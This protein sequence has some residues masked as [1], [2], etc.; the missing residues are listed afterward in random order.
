MV[1]LALVCA[2][3]A[4]AALAW[5]LYNPGIDYEF[6]FDDHRAIE[7]NADSR[8]GAP[9]GDLLEHDFWGDNLTCVRLRLCGW[10]AVACGCVYSC[11]CHCICVFLCAYACCVYVCASAVSTYVPAVSMCVSVCSVC[12]CVYGTCVCGCVFR[13]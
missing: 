6:T 8:W 9:W 7:R 3:A 10:V 13:L 12:V 4:A 1:R 2:A 11:E 5:A